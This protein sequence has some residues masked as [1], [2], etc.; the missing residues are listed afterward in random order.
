MSVCCVQSHHALQK[1]TLIHPSTNMSSSLLSVYKYLLQV[2]QDNSSKGF[3][4]LELLISVVISSLVVGG[5]LYGVVELATIDKRETRADQVQR[6]M[7]RAMDYI[8]DDLQE[9]VYVYPDPQQISDQLTDDPE[10][11]DNTGEVPV[12]AFWRIDPV[13]ENIPDCTMGDAALQLRCQVLAV[14]QSAYTLVVYSQ[15]E[16]DG[17]TNWPGQ[18]RIIRYELSMY[19]DVS[20]LDVRDGY[21]D[22]TDPDD[23]LAPFNVWEADGVPDGNADVLVDYVQG[24]SASSLNRVPLTDAGG[25]C[26]GYGLDNSTPPVPLYTIVPSDAANNNNNSF[27]ACVRNPVLDTGGTGTQDIYLFLRGNMQG[28]SGGVT[29]ASEQSSIPILETQVLIKGVVD[30]GFRQ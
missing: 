24:P 30:K 7:N 28:V 16:N 3:T 8:T 23:D 15:K 29:T 14:R 2:R 21:R 1:H 13:E 5:L 11:P 6:D 12:L 26:T 9:A 19:E 25:A 17:N 27:F 10:F 20:T 4:L 18:S 22:P